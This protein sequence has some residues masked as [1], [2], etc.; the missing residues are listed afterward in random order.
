MVGHQAEARAR[1]VAAASSIFRAATWAWWRSRAR[2][3]GSVFWVGESDEG[4]FW[5]PRSLER[6]TRLLGELNAMPAGFLGA[7][8]QA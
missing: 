5:E 2:P 7:L 4:E 8:P 1:T 3:R 6:L